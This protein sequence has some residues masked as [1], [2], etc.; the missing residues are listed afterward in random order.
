M[1]FVWNNTKKNSNVSN[2][3]QNQ[4]QTQSIWFDVISG[5]QK[6]YNKNLFTS[7]NGVKKQKKRIILW[8][9]TQ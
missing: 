9:T 6:H 1:C 3:S 7:N 8:I 4:P 5:K 2:V